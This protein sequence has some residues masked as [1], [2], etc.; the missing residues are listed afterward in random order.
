MGL[1]ALPQITARL[2]AHGMPEETPA[3][4]IASATLPEQRTVI[5]TLATLAERAEA[6]GLEPPATLVVGDVVGSAPVAEQD[7]AAAGAACLS[8]GPM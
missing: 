3:A 7:R 6:A 2:I 5:G 8:P 4:A 1:R